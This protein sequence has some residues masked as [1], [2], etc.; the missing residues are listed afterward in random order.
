[1]LVT[2]Q[3]SA[4]DL[5]EPKSL[6]SELKKVAGIA[7]SSFCWVAAEIKVKE[8]KSFI[9]QF[10]DESRK[11]SG[12]RLK[13]EIYNPEL[14]DGRSYTIKVVVMNEFKDLRRFC[15]AEHTWSFNS[16]VEPKDLEGSSN[17]IYLLLILLLLVPVAGYFVFR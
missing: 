2:T 6:L 17:L 8:S 4:T 15:V 16:N 14:V 11:K 5:G 7:P 9:F 1:M 13:A 10:G 3:E 12:S